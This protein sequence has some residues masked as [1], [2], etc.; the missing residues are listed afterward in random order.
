[1]ESNINNHSNN[2]QNN[3]I[4]TVPNR[5]NKINTNGHVPT[6]PTP[7]LTPIIPKAT[8][9]T[10]KPSPSTSTEARNSAT[11]RKVNRM[12]IRRHLHERYNR[13]YAP[14]ILAIS[15]I[16]VIALFAVLSTS[17]GAAYAFYQQ[18][19]PLLNGIA[20]HSLFQS[21][22]IYDRNGHLLYELYDHQNGHGRRT[23]VNYTQISPLL[24]NASIAAE[25][26]NFW[27]NNGVD[28][29]GTLRAA[30]TNL[31]SQTVVE[32]GSTITQQLVKNQLFLSQPRSLQIKSE[33]AILAY[34]LT[35][36][37]PKWKIMEM[38]LNTVYYGDLNYG[39]EAAAQDFF[40]IHPQCSRRLCKP[41]AS[42]LDLAQSSL[43]A[44][45]PQS[46][47][48]YNP[49]Y[50]KSVALDR[51]Q[52]VLQSMVA[53]R[54]ITEEQARQVE[55]ETAKF[56]FKSYASTQ[57]I[58]APHF[59]HYVIDQVLV[60][61]IG[62][63]NLLNGGYNIYTTLDL[64]LEKK[65]DQI[66]YGHLYKP[67]YDPYLGSYGPLNI[68]NNVNNA[69]VV[70][71]NPYNGEILAMDGSADYNNRGPQ[72]RGQYNSAIAL[73]QPGSSFKPVEYATAFEMGWYPAMIIP[74]HKTTYPSLLSGDPPTYY[75]PQNYD[76]K[77]HTGFPMTAR[78]AIANSFN[79]PAI[80]T[81][82]YAGI[83]NVLNMAGRLGLT[84]IAT[85]SP[86]SFGP[87]MAL[88]TSEVSL[89]HLTSAYATFAN[90]GVRVPPTSILEITD[91][92]GSPL[93][94]YNSAHPRGVRALRADIA[95][96]VNS[97][98]SDTKSRYHEFG[99]G[100]PLELDRPAAAKTGTTQSFRDNWTIGYTPYVT[101][102]VWAGNSDNTTM[103]NIIGITGA[104]PIWHDVMEYVSSL[105]NY[106]PDDFNKP[107]DVHASAVSAYTGLAPHPGEPTVTDWFIDGTQPTIQ[108]TFT[109]PSPCN[110]DKCKPPHCKKHC[111]VPPTN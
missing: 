14:R 93:Y 50:N 16:F 74:D 35:K 26:H 52:T 104:G 10:I 76:Q 66:A 57:G 86:S 103:N 34:G 7:V 45:L 61:L 12:I 80:D 37:Y 72:V 70:V 5:E 43:L 9:Q 20:D 39:I 108:G 96:L 4:I 84:E 28:L 27:V 6:T 107:S 38:Y 3:E 65:V 77:F 2:H 85:R 44:G 42:Q 99:A 95:F 98:L 60:P 11:L 105:Y 100:N 55:A 19:L 53:L 109:N 83:Q 59:V 82:E 17:V 15:L 1:M 8:I 106:P 30:V 32:G 97:I 46:P 111:D 94:S 24:I 78:N 22:H 62:A 33:E 13:S 102:G 25:D 91:N 75:T 56:H 29:Q 48:Y 40:N 92:Q 88:G 64:N 81:L 67:L 68:Q 18:Q 23:Y 51:Q 49:V 87:S 41:A 36:Q 47:S 21:T 71:M 73:R 63:Q 69:A 90:Q 31:Q 101:V 54:M 79:I 58:Q 110:G 89:L